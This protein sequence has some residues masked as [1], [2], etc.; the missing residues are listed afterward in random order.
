LRRPFRSH[1]T[2]YSKWHLQT[3]DVTNL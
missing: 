1:S 2:S 3:G